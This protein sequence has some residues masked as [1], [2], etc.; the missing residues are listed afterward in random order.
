MPSGSSCWQAFFDEADDGLLLVCLGCLKAVDAL[1][2][3]LCSSTALRRLCGSGATLSLEAQASADQNVALRIGISALGVEAALAS[4]ACSG[5]ALGALWAAASL[6]PREPR[7]DD[8]GGLQ[9]MPVFARPLYWAL[10][11]GKREHT[12]SG[13]GRGGGAPPR[14]VEEFLE[15][16]LT[17]E[18]KLLAT[19]AS[20]SSRTDTAISS[21]SGVSAVAS[22]VD[23]ALTAALAKDGAI[24]AQVTAATAVALVDAEERL[25]EMVADGSIARTGPSGYEAVARRRCAAALLLSRLRCGG[26]GGAEVSDLADAVIDLQAAAKSLDETISGYDEEGYTL[27]CP[28]LARA[29]GPLPYGHWWAFLGDGKENSS[30][31]LCS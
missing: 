5:S 13:T 16:F 7:E 12:A 14:E 2:V 26:G 30:F 10:E 18:L 20:C 28:R 25:D 21:C 24:G 3:S 15:A 29:R 31:G 22:A 19:R 23:A 6:E 4:A 11:L 8:K 9:Q 17:W 27:A 1:H